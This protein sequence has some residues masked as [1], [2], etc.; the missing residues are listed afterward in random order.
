MNSFVVFSP[1]ANAS[2][3]KHH[4]PNS[5]EQDS[6]CRWR[7]KSLETVFV[8]LETL[9][10]HVIHVA[11]PLEVCSSLGIVTLAGRLAAALERHSLC[12][13]VIGDSRNVIGDSR[14]DVTSL[15]TFTMM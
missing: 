12:C 4:M 8:P 10:I 13:D 1:H 11:M 15:E 5:L 9:V 6:L 3:T 7:H 14:Y 2:I